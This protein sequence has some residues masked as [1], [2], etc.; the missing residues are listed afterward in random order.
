MEPGPSTVRPHREAA[1]LAAHL[2]EGGLRF[3]IV[4]DPNGRLIGV[5][6]REDLERA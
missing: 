5:A 1:E 6:R 3:A 2:A 4:T